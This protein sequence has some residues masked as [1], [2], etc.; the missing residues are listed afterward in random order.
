MYF[1]ML[2]GVCLVAVVPC[3]LCPAEERPNVLFVAVDD[4]NDWVGC[5]GGNP[6]TKTPNLDKFARSRAMVMS[7]ACCP[8]AVCCPSRTAL[9]TGLLP[10]TTGVYSN[11]QNLKNA[12]KAKDAV[13]LPQYF[14]RHGYH[15]LS[16]GKIFHKHQTAKG[17]DEGQWAFDEFH[18]A[19]GRGNVVERIA[20]PPIEGVE[21][22][23]TDFAWGA[24][25]AP[26]EETR[27][28]RTCA[29]GAEQL[30]RDFDMPFFLAIGLAKPHLPWFVP[31]EFFDMHPLD[32]VQ[33][34]EFR[35]DDLDD[36]VK[37]NGATLLK[38]SDRFVLADRAGMHRQA[39]RAYL[40]LSQANPKG[41]AWVGGQKNS[42]TS[43]NLGRMES[44]DHLPTS[45]ARKFSS[46]YEDTKTDG[47]MQAADRTTLGQER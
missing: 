2:F 17:L 9:L 40:A 5:L 39:A 46:E 23:G 4:L 1:R 37:V 11:S 18:N 21:P 45:E 15:S 26:F 20:P 7:K 44:N 27:D 19:G 35:Y 24:T 28:Y 10:S 22:H 6:Q 3:R 29:W 30:Q 38:P 36:I 33:P 12:P 41:F 25:D 8:A 34:I 13:T 42:K 14:S 43:G 31:Q 16:S 47:A 32:Q